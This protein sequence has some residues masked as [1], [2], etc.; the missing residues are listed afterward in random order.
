MRHSLAFSHSDD[1]FVQLIGCSILKSDNVDHI[2][3][4]SRVRR[5]DLSVYD[6]AGHDRRCQLS[7]ILYISCY[8]TYPLPVHMLARHIWTSSSTS[9]ATCYQVFNRVMISI[10]EHRETARLCFVGSLFTLL[11]LKIWNCVR[12]N[13]RL[14]TDDVPATIWNRWR[15]VLRYRGTSYLTVQ[16]ISFFWL[17]RPDPVFNL[18]SRHVHHILIDLIINTRN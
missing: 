5:R 11:L 16:L 7:F 18:V 4:P 14:R 8:V 2:H 15:L 10:S 12:V 17:S 9:E 6:A 3:D 1:R 13:S